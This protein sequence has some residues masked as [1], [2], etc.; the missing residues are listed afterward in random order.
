MMDRYVSLDEY[1]T[2]GLH[3]TASYYSKITDAGE[4]FDLIKESVLTEEKHLI[5]GGGSNV[6]FLD[7]FYNGLVIHIN[8]KGKIL[9]RE[10][11]NDVYIRVAAGESWSDFVVEMVN[12]GYGGLENLSMIPGTVGAAP[13]QNIGAYGTELK[14]VFYQLTAIDLSNGEKV[15]FNRAECEFGYRTSVFKTRLKDRFIITHVDFKLKKHPV[16]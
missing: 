13:I 3:V 16:I 10:T 15:L 14:D 12:Q 2:F 9:L 11:V 6:L 5:L 7:D 1:N 8:S 4:I